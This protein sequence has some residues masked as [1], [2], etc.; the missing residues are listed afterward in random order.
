MH[1]WFNTH[2]MN[3]QKIKDFIAEFKP[4][5]VHLFSFAVWN[6]AELARFNLG[7]QPMLEDAF[8]FKLCTTWTVDDDIIPMCCSV[9]HLGQ[10]SVTFNEASEFW[11]KHES[12]RLCMRHTFKDTIG[13]TEVVLLDDAVINENFE[14]PDLQIKGR[15]LNIDTL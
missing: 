4:E 13:E 10:G 14:W 9:M 1:G 15:I 8:D 7:L 2:L 6:Q 3:V 11:S 5:F 12:F